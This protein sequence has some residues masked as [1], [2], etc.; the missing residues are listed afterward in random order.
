MTAV[1][2]DGVP[3]AVTLKD[4]KLV[5]VRLMTGEDAASVRAFAAALPEDDLLFL[6]MDITQAS[7]VGAWVRQIELGNSTTVLGHVEGELAGFAT[8]HREPARWTRGVGEL[9]VNVGAAF[10]GR[11]LG[12][13]LT[14]L[15][16][17]VARSLGI[18]KVVAQMATDQAAARQ[19]FKHFGFE[20]DAVLRDWVEDRAGQLRDLVVMS[21]DLRW[22]FA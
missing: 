7:V 16:F 1:L 22:E 2:A 20:E 19:V 18:R 9:R 3:A 14:W 5:D 17:D 12:R 10:R 21:Y 4:G 8:V 6:R 15:I 11:G 13:E